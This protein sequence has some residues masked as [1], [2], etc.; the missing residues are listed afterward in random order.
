MTS[1]WVLIPLA[2]GSALVVNLFLTRWIVSVAH[3]KNWLDQPNNR[4]VHN[5]PV[6]RLGG[7]GMFA[8][9]GLICVSIW[10]LEFLL[11]G[12]FPLGSAG[13]PV[14]LLFVGLG[15]THVLGVLDDFVRL[16]AVYKFLLQLLGAFL[17]IG[18]GLSFDHLAIPF[19]RLSLDLGPFAPFVTLLWVVG[20]TNA[21]NLLDGMDGLAGGFATIS[22]CGLGIFFVATGLVLPAFVSFVAVGA[23]LAFLVSNL[24]PAKLFMGDSGSLMLGYLLAVLPLWGGNASLFS[25]FWLLPVILVLIPLADTLAAILRRLRENR[26][27][28]SPDKQH[29]HHK[30]LSM[31]LSTTQILALVYSATVVTTLPIVLAGFFRSAEFHFW[32]SLAVGLVILVLFSS[33]HYTHRSFVARHK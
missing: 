14:L 30:L 16:R 4:T 18:A 1:P 15:V 5:D 22:L 31:G 10:L 25:Q 23:L 9:I 19:T 3:R 11:P 28:W 32:T 13:V 24:P 17:A 21:V 20:V 33:L 29:L 12:S 26:P 8:S 2:T 7:V 27:I 6:P